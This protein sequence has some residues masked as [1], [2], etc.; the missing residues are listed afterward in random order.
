M[1]AIESGRVR[2]DVI[3]ATEFPDLVGKYRV[4]A[5][6]KTIINDTDSVEGSLPEEAFLERVLA[7]VQ[8]SPDQDSISQQA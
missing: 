8:P 4:S 6:P 7:S 2:A 3:E 1:F 5:V